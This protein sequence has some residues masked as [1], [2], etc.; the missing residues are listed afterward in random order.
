MRN[1]FQN[2]EFTTPQRHR[3]PGRERDRRARLRAAFPRHEFLKRLDPYYKAIEKAARTS[4]T[5]PRSRISSTPSTSS[6]SRGSRPTSPTRTA[7]ST[8]RAKSSTTCATR[9][10]QALKDEFGTTLASPEVVILDPCTGTGNFIVNL[11][12][13]MPGKALAEAYQNRLFANEVMLL[14]YYVASLN[15]EHAYYER[16]SA[17][18][19][20][21][22]AVLRGH[23]RH[24]RSPADRNLFTVWPTPSAS[25]AR[26]NAAITVIIGNPPYNVGQKSENDNNQNRKYQGVDERV[27]DTYAKDSKAT[28]KNSLSD[29]YVKFFRWATDRLE[30]PRWH[31]LLRLEQQLRGS[32]RLRRDAQASC[33]GLPANRPHRPA[34]QRAPESE[35]LREPAHNVFGIQV[36]VGITLADARSG[37]TM[38]LR[39]H[40]VPEMWRKREKL[41]FLAE[42]QQI[43]LANSHAGRRTHLARARTRLTSIAQ[44]VPI[45]EMFGSAP[46]PAYQN[47]PRRRGLRLES[48]K[49]CRAACKEFV[50]DYNAEVYRHKAD[51]DADWP[52]HV[53]WS[54]RLKQSF[55]AANVVDIRRRQDSCARCIGRSQR[56][57]LFRSAFLTSESISG[58]RFRAGRL[59]LPTSVGELR[60]QCA[61]DRHRSRTCT[62]APPVMLTSAS[63][64]PPQRL[65]RRPIPPALLPRLHHETKTSS[66]TSTRCCI[67][68]C[69]ANATPPTSSAS[70]RAFRSRPISPR[71]PRQAKNWRGSTWTTNRSSR[72]RS[73]SSRTKTCPTRSA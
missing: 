35:A 4:A 54:R 23:A 51:P 57:A 72:G 71:S 38:R 16:M 31:R 39:Y 61:D 44:F 40:R 10:R 60:F 27:R 24:G 30:G 18:R 48:R 53:K 63:P 56:V 8:R 29:V 55:S 1:L 65:R 46:L 11:I 9:S 43:S 62:S 2:P 41:E 15:I 36:G 12:E 14:P 26:S 5:S 69:T 70:C 21:R 42:G 64:F 6:S 58:R 59:L 17:V 47:K 25:S 19:A 73:N 50:A 3:G 45:A 33:S 67:I 7:S 49:R 37:R 34:R 28:N 20:V 32:D 68:R 22:R 52:D 66:T 13:R